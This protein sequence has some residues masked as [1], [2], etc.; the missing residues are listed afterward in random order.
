M[1][2]SRA[3]FLAAGA[4]AGTLAAVGLPE[5]VAAAPATSNDPMRGM[6]FTMLRDGTTD[7]LGIRTPRGIVDVARAA[8]A[9]G[10]TSAPVTTDDVI[11]GRGNV[12]ALRGIVA[13][14]P[15]SAIRAESAVAYAPVVT[16]PAKIVCVGLNYRAHLAETGEKAP[17]YPDLFN[18]YNS[19]LNRHNGTIAISNV[20]GKEFDYESELVMIVGKTA[21]KVPE[22]EA[23]NYVFGYT[24]GNDFSLREV[25]LRTSQWMTG[26]TPDDFAP[27]G[28]WL[29][30][31]D[32]V[33][34]P[35]TLDIHT[36]VNDETQPRQSANTSQMI[37]SCAH[38]L[39]YTSQFITLNPGDVIFTGTPNGVIIG[40]PP[41]KRVWL[42]PGDR[43]RT[44][45]SKL[46]ELH[47][48]L[49]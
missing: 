12:A 16:A 7:H 6:T 44:V 8:D 38:I 30:T 47:I 3:T 17:P 49:T 22:S 19:A 13:N 32:Q 34:D 33:P 2:P 25:Q 20:P 23:L 39:S 4:A 14:A 29:V 18:K 35:Q 42:K 40:M 37:F 5:T 28:P 46:G 43:V 26:K 45:I 1:S 21:S 48:S 36:F 10:I 9:L 11:A 41:E 27:I 31:A 15:A 24:T